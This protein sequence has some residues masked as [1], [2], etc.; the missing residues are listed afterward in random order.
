VLVQDVRDNL[1]Y[2]RSSPIS[3]CWSVQLLVT[4]KLISM[5]FSEEIGL[6]K[7]LI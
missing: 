6:N 1:D 7:E 3:V 4:Q 5:K 2:H